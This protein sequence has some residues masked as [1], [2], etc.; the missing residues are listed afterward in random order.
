MALAKNMT[1]DASGNDLG[2][3]LGDNLQSQVEDSI[4]ERRKKLLLMSNQ[5]GQNYG[6]VGL[7]TGQS[8]GINGM[9]MNPAMLGQGGFGA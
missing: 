2:L 6:A 7:G 1:I 4:L 3:G 8:A 9:T 5:P